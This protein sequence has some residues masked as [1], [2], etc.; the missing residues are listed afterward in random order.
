MGAEVLKD[1]LARLGWDIDEAGYQKFSSALG[2]ATKRAMLFGA[3]ITAAATAAYYGIYKIAENNA[4][5]LNTSESLGM[6][7]A[8]LREMNFAATIMGSSSDALKSS[9]E[10]LKSAMAGATIGGGGL[11]TFARL[12][13]NIRDANG[14]LRNTD[15]VLED[16]A[17]RIKG[18]DRAKGE[19]FLG[20]LGIDKSL[21]RMLTQDVSGL[22]EAYRGMYAATGM[23]AEKSAEQSREF[24]KEVKILKEVFGLLAETVGIALI[25]KAGKDVKTFRQMLVSNFG[26]IVS[27]IKPVIEV[28][29]TLAGFFLTLAL[30]VFQ[31]VGGIINWF[32]SLDSSTQ[33]LIAS[34]LGFAAAWKFLNLAFLASPLG[35][36]ITGLIALVSLFDDLQ[37]YMEGGE[38]LVNWGP[39]VGQIEAIMGELGKLMDNLKVLWDLVKGP[40]L[41]AFAEMGSG[42]IDTLTGIL[43]IVINLITLL[44][45]LANLDWAAAWQSALK[46]AQA[47]LDTVMGIA[48]AT[49]VLS[50]IKGIAGIFGGGGNNE[51][52]APVLG[53]SPAFA[54]ATAGA[55]MPG[56][57]E[58]NQTT[59][60]FV[61][62]SD[63]PEAVGRSVANQ[64]RNVNNDLVRHS[65]GAAR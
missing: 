57:T 48:K 32:K 8:R 55:G 40:L 16:V 56:K 35:M 39:W 11:A 42:A 27:A 17:K 45:N 24:V 14:H 20:Q 31:W 2:T 10:G 9:L 61:D 51:Q 62:G 3:G 19:M 65:K 25:G 34:V 59:N 13:I 37:T 47:I 46:V 58:L 5:L 54:A 36:I 38:S 53:P 18:M 63:D 1:F 21:Y 52:S 26:P 44:T 12:G 28:V 64:Q 49:G 60:V 30:R 15:A 23:D 43:S 6:N 33:T 41:S 50:A 4:D 29:L 22:T 7:V